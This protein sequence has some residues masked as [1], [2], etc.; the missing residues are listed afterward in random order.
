MH[1]TLAGLYID[2]RANAVEAKPL[3]GC[4]D[5][6]ELHDEALINTTLGMVNSA[7]FVAAIHFPFILGCMDTDCVICRPNRRFPDVICPQ[8]GCNQGSLIRY[9][10]LF[11]AIRKAWPQSILFGP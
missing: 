7:M 5:I 8:F 3:D 11:Q 1:T 6:I 9:D 2:T 4:G 10:A